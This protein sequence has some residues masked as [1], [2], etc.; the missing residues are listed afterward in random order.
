MAV[1]ELKP[2]AHAGLVWV[3]STTPTQKIL[4]PEGFKG[5]KDDNEGIDALALHVAEITERSIQ[6]VVCLSDDGV[7][8]EALLINIIR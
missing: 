2:Q 8:D 6:R 3:L 5:V 4:N 1:A 7:V